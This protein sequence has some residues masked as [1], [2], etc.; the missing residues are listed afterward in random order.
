[1]KEEGEQVAASNVRLAQQSNDKLQTA[2]WPQQLPR[3][4]SQRVPGA[5]LSQRS[6]PA[7][8]RSQVRPRGCE[9]GRVTPPTAGSVEARVPQAYLS[10]S[11][12]QLPSPAELRAAVRENNAPSGG[13]RPAL[14]A[15]KLAR[16]PRGPAHRPPPTNGRAGTGRHP[17]SLRRLGG[18]EA[19]KGA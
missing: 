8:D 11:R 5:G 2:R 10:R 14:A 16:P 17:G 7:C 13:A 4:P 6:I 9:R 15:G 19:E 12:S 1:M 3:G 18:P